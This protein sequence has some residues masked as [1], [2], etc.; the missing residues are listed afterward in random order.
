MA[1]F[2]GARKVILLVLGT[3]V[4]YGSLAIWLG[5]SEQRLGNTEL[6]LVPSGIALSMLLAWGWRALPGITLGGLAAG[7]WCFATAAGP[8]VMSHGAWFLL[9]PLG[10]TA[11]AAISYGLLRFLVP[12]I[13]ETH[14]TADYTRFLLVSGPLGS[15]IGTVF[16][17]VASGLKSGLPVVFV[18]MAG[19]E[20][21]LIDLVAG[22]TIVAFSL[23]FISKAPRPFVPFTMVSAAGVSL[24]GAGVVF[25]W[26]AGDVTLIQVD[27]SLTPMQ[28]NT[29]LG[30]VLSGAGLFAVINTRQRLAISLGVLL[31]ALGGLTL[32]QYVS[33]V[34]LGIDEL[35]MSHYIKVNTTFP[36][37][38]APNTALCFV[39]F[40]LSLVRP[41]SETGSSTATSTLCSIVASLG[42]TSL[43]SY[44]A[45]IDSAYGWA[46]MTPMAI[47]TAVG[48]LILGLG[49][50]AREVVQIEGVT[51]RVSL[52]PIPTGVALAATTLWVWQAVSHD[53][54]SK[55]MK[56]ARDRAVD[57]TRLIDREITY[58]NHALGRMAARWN[59]E[60]G[61]NKAEWT[62]DAKSHLRDF[63]TIAAL[64]WADNTS[65]IRWLEPLEGN[66]E[67]VGFDLSSNPLGEAALA[68]V[69]ETHVQESTDVFD[70]SGVGRS[71]LLF[72]PVMDGDSLTGY[73]VGLYRVDRLFENL[74]PAALD[75]YQFRVLEHDKSIFL[76]DPHTPWVSDRN[77]QWLTNGEMRGGAWSLEMVPK[78]NWLAGQRSNLPLLILF[79]G[80]VLSAVTTVALH[81]LEAVRGQYDQV[82][83]SEIRLRQILDSVPTGMITVDSRGRISDINPAGESQFGYSANELLGQPVEI[84]VPVSLREVHRKDRLG[85]T[86]APETRSMGEGRDLAAIKKN[87]TCFPVEIALA[88][89]RTRDGLQ[90]LALVTDITERDEARR[91]LE[92]HTRA[93]ELI[94]RDLDE[95]AYV[96]SHDLK[97][98]LTAIE[99][100][101][102]WLEEDTAAIMPEASMQ[103]LA[104]IKSRV[105]RMGTLLEDLLH[106]SRAGRTANKI[107]SVNTL[108]MV[109]E[110]AEMLHG[111]IALQVHA[112]DLP[113]LD[114]V[115][116]P[117]QQVF[118]NL[119]SNAI[120]HHDREC[121]TLTITASQQDG[122]FVFC[123]AD[124]GPGIPVEYHKR[125]FKMFQTL[126]PRDEVEGSGMGLALVRKLVQRY[127]GRVNLVETSGRGT[128][129]EFTWPRTITGD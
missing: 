97:A 5:A 49:G 91:K 37:R 53:E 101:V 96:A 35:F 109:R 43:V 15:A 128:S 51:R 12:N 114:T 28:F 116:I 42:F 27:P 63:P 20:W 32:L 31:I 75:N 110:I 60:Q 95:F 48:F 80:M 72:T 111:K 86:R 34:N 39:L 17:L 67:I 120:K 25:G 9:L 129:V 122:H 6:P 105:A 50:I 24:L 62:A 78:G 104:L 108:E 99:S 11:Q 70:L 84:L 68:K 92:A 113:T 22:V 13:C 7:A 44:L 45:G 90:V 126:K 100:L 40:G 93:L 98:P 77:S 19:A 66:E 87:G 33:G 121:C 76:S 58:H 103:H 14:S 83:L 89:F 36:G 94:N 106:Y 29:A 118:Q 10:V 55:I 59:V 8:L 107:E 79:S 73:I 112:G 71:F 1:K 52:S 57:I 61:T 21:W 26:I 2:D 127:G 125:V 85:F 81:L 3:A 119:I 56:L 69:R 41:L 82:Q 74:S 123:V 4:L 124:D 117:L 64:A 23:G 115:R 102:L 16:V 18:A 46:H 88:P 30:L 54:Q 38:M 47:H 65:R